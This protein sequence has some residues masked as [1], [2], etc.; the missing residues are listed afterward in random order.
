MIKEA[1]KKIGKKLAL[2]LCVSAMCIGGAA[3][4]AQAAETAEVQE[5]ESG[6]AEIAAV[7]VDEYLDF[8]KVVGKK[9][10]GWNSYKYEISLS[11]SGRVRLDF[12]SYGTKFKV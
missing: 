8:G 7:S 2:T 4:S 6:S 11:K 1:L 9:L 5:S 12:E 10:T 3:V